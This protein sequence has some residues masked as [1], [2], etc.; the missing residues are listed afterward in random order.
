MYSSP[1]RSGTLVCFSILLLRC[2]RPLISDSIS[3]YL[4]ASVILARDYN[5]RRFGADVLRNP[6]HSTAMTDTWP[7]L[8]GREAEVSA[9][10]RAY[11]ASFLPK[12]FARHR[13]PN[14]VV[15]RLWAS[16]D[17]PRQLMIAVR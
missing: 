15:Q 7:Y 12:F 17:N 16:P 3:V 6:K 4:S 2:R 1:A 5:G 8:R 13:L 10:R 9:R 14:P 11:N